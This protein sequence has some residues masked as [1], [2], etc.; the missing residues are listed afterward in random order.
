MKFKKYSARCERDGLK[1]TPLVFNNLGEMSDEFKR[2]LSNTIAK[3]WSDKESIP[4]SEALYLLS[5]RIQFRIVKLTSLAMRD[6]I[7]SVIA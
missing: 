7:S 2:F 4:Y 6:R 1:Y 5:R 3:N